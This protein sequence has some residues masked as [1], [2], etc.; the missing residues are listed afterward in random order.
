MTTNQNSLLA[1]ASCKE[2]LIKHAYWD[3]SED[4][5]LSMSDIVENYESWVQRE[6]FLVLE[7]R[8]E[9]HLTKFK[10]VHASK[11]G[12]AWY[13]E[14]TNEK[15]LQKVGHI[16]DYEYFSKR[17]RD[18]EHTDM[19]MVT[20]TYEKQEL[21][22][23]KE[24]GNHFAEFMN[25]LRSK[26][27]KIEFLRAW[28]SHESGCPHIHCLIRHKTGFLCRKINDKWRIVGEDYET[29]KSYWV[30]GYSDVI[31]ISSHNEAFGYI[32][33]YITKSWN[34]DSGKHIKTLA[35]LWYFKKRCYSI[36]K[37]FFNDCKIKSDLI[38]LMH[39]LYGWSF[40]GVMS[41]S[42]FIDLSESTRNFELELIRKDI[43]EPLLSIYCS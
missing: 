9:N 1:T 37:L 18:I 8:K 36:S 20:L 28:E 42:E 25:R 34:G 40:V 5:A 2:N 4:M 35:M 23:W 31:A 16:P 26:Y 7:C 32:G 27:G 24:T 11:R 17:S 41:E 38:T 10:K 39:N 6:M 29:I 33:K 21:T 3:I 13:V 12:D 15:F 43:K 19:I 30:R 14:R 22:T